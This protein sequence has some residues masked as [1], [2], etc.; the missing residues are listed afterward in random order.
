MNLFKL[1]SDEA[2]ILAYIL[3][4]GKIHLMQFIHKKSGFTHDEC[5]KI[6]TKFVD[7]GLVAIEIQ[8]EVGNSN[9]FISPRSGLRK[10]IPNYHLTSMI[11]M[12]KNKTRQ[13]NLKLQRFHRDQDNMI[14]NNKKKDIIEKNISSV[15]AKITMLEQNLEL[16]QS[17]WKNRNEQIINK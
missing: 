10:V 17:E 14:T 11:E 7:A 16:V 2:K 6:I 8:S 12:L 13:F 1:D 4:H 9:M 5:M 15:K 3:E